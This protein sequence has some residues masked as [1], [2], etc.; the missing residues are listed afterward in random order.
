MATF[1]VKVVT[2]TEYLSKDKMLK[3]KPAH[4]PAFFMCLLWIFN[5]FL[6]V[7]I[8]A[9]K[10][11]NTGLLSAGFFQIEGFGNIHGN[12]GTGFNIGQCADFIQCIT[13]AI[14]GVG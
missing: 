12:H 1:T 11:N 8:A 6:R 4:L 13:P 9:E 2:S 3:K 14:A 5:V 10:L 7:F